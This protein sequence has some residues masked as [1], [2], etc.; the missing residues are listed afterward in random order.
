MYGCKK[1]PQENQSQVSRKVKV[2][3]LAIRLNNEGCD[4]LMKARGNSKDSLIKGIEYFDKAIAIDSSY[5]LAY[6]DKA[7]NINRLG[8]IDAALQVLSQAQKTNLESPELYVIRG[9]L[10]EKSGRKDS[11]NSCYKTT[12]V[13]YDMLYK[14]KPEDWNL[15]INRVFV[16]F[17]LNG[18]DPKKELNA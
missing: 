5:T 17:I 3:S 8:N 7:K 13:Y 9:F 11:A 15:I 14:K 12:L 10:N 1:Q 4:L 16:K 6:T 2:D 18:T